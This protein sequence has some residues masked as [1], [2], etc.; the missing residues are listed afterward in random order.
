MGS[1]EGLF[2]NCQKLF[3][4]VGLYIFAE[5]GVEPCDFPISILLFGGG[6]PGIG[7]KFKFVFV[8]TSLQSSLVWW[9]GCG[10]NFL[11]GRDL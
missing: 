6:V 11:I 4:N 9:N 2:D 5:G 10:E 1:W 7:V 3:S 8:L